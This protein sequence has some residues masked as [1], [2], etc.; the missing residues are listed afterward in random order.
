MTRISME[1]A[2]TRNNNTNDWIASTTGD[3]IYTFRGMKPEQKNLYKSFYV[4]QFRMFDTTRMASYRL[5]PLEEVENHT[6]YVSA[7]RK[8]MLETIDTGIAI[9]SE[10]S[11]TYKQIL[12]RWMHGFDN[13]LSKNEPDVAINFHKSTYDKQSLY[14]LI[15]TLYEYFPN[16]VPPNVGN[17]YMYIQLTGCNI[18]E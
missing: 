18:K 7:I 15:Q 13:F 17:F 6:S 14:W 3:L 5:T 1:Q 4:N 12:F 16:E 11:H 10:Y 2:I 8:T 9:R